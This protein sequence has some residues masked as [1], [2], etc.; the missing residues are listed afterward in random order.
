MSHQGLVL[1][2]H[3]S[4]CDFFPKERVDMKHEDFTAFGCGKIGDL[5]FVHAGLG[6]GIVVTNYAGLGNKKTSRD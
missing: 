6:I 2:F 3:R 1:G 5:R 4:G